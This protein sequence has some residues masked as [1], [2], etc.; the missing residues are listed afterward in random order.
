MAIKQLEKKFEP[1]RESLYEF[2]TFYWK[3]E[4]KKELDDNWHIRLLCARLEDVFYGRIMRLMINVPP[5]SLK[6]ELV[7]IA[8]PARCM[9]KRN[10]IK[11]MDVSYSAGIAEENSS[12]CRAMYLSDTYQKIFPRATRIKD[13]Q[14]TKKHRVNESGGQYYAAGADGTITGKG[15]DIMV[16]DDPLKPRDAMSDLVRIG[17]NNNYHNTL[18]SRFDDMTVGAVIIIM[19]RLHDDDLC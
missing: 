4:L 15:C 17:V 2:F 10:G 5:R 16:I 1:Q 9:G 6:T 13:D 19:Q 7:S 18:E 3:E 14:N 8:F 12:K 11:F